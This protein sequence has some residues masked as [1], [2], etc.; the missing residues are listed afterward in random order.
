VKNGKR[1]RTGSSKGSL[2]KCSPVHSSVLIADRN[3]V[4]ETS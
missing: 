3:R 2:T 4:D 1:A